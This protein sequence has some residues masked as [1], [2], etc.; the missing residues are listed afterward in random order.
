MRIG[1]AVLV[2]LASGTAALA[3]ERPDPDHEIKR[4][5][6]VMGT[7]VHV[8][9]WGDDDELAARAIGDAFAELDR[10][11]ALMTHYAADSAVGKINATAGARRGV[12][13]DDETFAVIEKAQQTSRLTGG[14]FDITVGA[15]WDLWKFGTDQD[16][17]V[18]SDAAIAERVKKVD[19]RRIKI[20]RAGKTVRLARKGTAITLG[21]IAKGY[22]VDRA[23][24]ILRQAGLS[25]FIVQAGGDLYVSGRKGSRNWLVGIRDPRGDRAKTFAVAPVEDMTFSTSGDYER[26]FVAD[27]V[28]YHHILDPRTGRPAMRC[29]SVTVMAKD[30]L[31]AD[32]LST[33]LFVMGAEAGMK[34]VEKLPDVEAVFVDADNQVHVSSGLEGKLKILSPPTG[35]I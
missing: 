12:A 13:V 6:P 23:V 22:A 16:G 35:G 33:G 14:A 34:L 17:S 10:L 5:K 4:S 18:P 25:D 31:T 9:V 11:D 8:T 26:S 20:D 2:A 24:A 3:D 19:Y 15:F 28:R 1:A 29:R 30:A 32:G 7:L 21:G 27:G